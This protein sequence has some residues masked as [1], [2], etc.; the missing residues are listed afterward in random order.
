MVIP[1]GY[2]KV[3]CPQCGATL[4][5]A[6]SGVIQIKCYRCKVTT[7]FEIDRGSIKHTVESRE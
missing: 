5:I 7:N 3:K 1:V 2:V 6:K 4:L